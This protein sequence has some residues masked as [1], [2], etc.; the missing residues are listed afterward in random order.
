MKERGITLVALVITI[1]VL[2]ILAGVTINLTLGEDGIIRRAQQALENY[3]NAAQREQAE[4]GKFNGELEN[5]LKGNNSV[6]RIQPGERAEKTEQNNYTDGKDVATIPEG[7][8]VSGIAEEQKIEDGLVI[9][10][11]PEAEVAEVNWNADTDND[12]IK[13]V[14]ENYNQ[15]VWI[16]CGTWDANTQKYSTIEYEN[17]EYYSRKDNPNSQNWTSYAYESDVADQTD[18]KYKGKTGWHNPSEQ[19]ATAKESISKYG[20][21]YIAR[22]EAGVPEN[23]NFYVASNSTSDKAYKR[24]NNMRDVNTY[25]PVSKKGNQVWN[26]ISQINA[27]EVSEN[28][29]KNSNSVNSYL[30]DSNAWNYICKDIL[31]DKVKEDIRNSA[32]YG[33]CYDNTKTNY[34]GITGLFAKHICNSSNKL[35]YATQYEYKQI[36]E[37]IAPKGNGDNRLELAT[38]AS[39]DFNKYNIYDMA[40][41]LWEWTTETTNA[42]YGTE[43]KTID[44]GVRRG[45]GFNNNGSNNPVVRSYG[46]NYAT[47]N[48]SDFGFRPVIY[49]K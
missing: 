37:G 15:F 18:L 33:N 4:L 47:E 34:E 22:Y 9:Y 31:E 36:S 39:E 42:E 20:G 12:G 17:A 46:L 41:N 38:G 7:F 40:G 32:K 21:F 1:I 30:I 44:Y 5:V 35:T 43:H 25:K 10:D 48:S 29:Y 14:Q 45:G 24:E 23:A 49:V 26:L 28:M 2:L 19:I 8:T 3:T 27:K 11:I 6:V 16:P 13:D